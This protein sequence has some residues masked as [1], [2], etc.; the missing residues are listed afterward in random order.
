M[1]GRCE[2]CWKN[3]G[4]DPRV[5]LSFPNGRTAHICND[6]ANQLWHMHDRDRLPADG[7]VF[8]RPVPETRHHCYGVQ[9]RVT[10]PNGDVLIDLNSRDAYFVAKYG[11]AGKEWVTLAG[12]SD[13]KRAA[14]AP[15]AIVAGY[16]LD[17]K[18]V[19]LDYSS[20]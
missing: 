9:F 1:T 18:A 8:P 15:G 14:L 11:H 19:E 16:Y 10:M 5:K 2:C 17:I 4:E 20:E 7:E 6:C 12:P 3:T 13:V